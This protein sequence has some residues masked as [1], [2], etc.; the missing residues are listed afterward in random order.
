MRLVVDVDAAGVR[1]AL[2]RER[3]AELARF[4][5]RAEGVR[6]ALVSLTFVSNSA[7]ARLNRRHLGHAGATDVISFG[8]Q[9]PQGA[10]P[11]A[12]G[13]VYIAPEVARRN[14]RAHG[15]TAREET[16]RLVVH[17]L[18]HVL[19]HDHPE[20]EDRT[21]SDMWRRQERLLSRAR[22]AGTW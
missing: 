21:V 3:A 2:G 1:P 5:L 16:A 17:G 7:I 11:V 22:E 13:D 12:M 4:V 19:G 6:D 10:P 18:L 15:C 20:G 14:A 9:G 8:L